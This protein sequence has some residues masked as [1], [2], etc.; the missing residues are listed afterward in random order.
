[1]ERKN[2]TFEYENSGSYNYKVFRMFSYN[3]NQNGLYIL[4]RFTYFTKSIELCG[5]VCVFKGLMCA[6]FCYEDIIP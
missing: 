2:R 4:Q 5:H 6:L 3:K 1:M